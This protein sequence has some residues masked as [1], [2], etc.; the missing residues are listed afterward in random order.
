M[1]KGKIRSGKSATR[2]RSV[3]PARKAIF[4]ILQKIENE[5]AFSSELLPIYEEKLS[6][7]DRGLCHKIT[8]GV[9]RNKIYLDKSIEILTGKKSEKFDRAVLIA[10]RIGL[11]QL[12]FTD[13]IPI[14]SAVN[15]SVEMVNQ[16]KKRSAAGLV[17]AV[18]R[19]AAGEKVKFEFKDEIEKISIENS[20]PRWLLEKWISQFGL[21][22]TAKLVAA[23]NQTPNLS[24]RLTAKADEKTLEI[25]EKTGLQVRKSEIVPG[26]FKVSESSE[27]LRLYAEEGKIYFQDEGSQIV[28]H[29]VDLKAG[30]SFL[31][32]CAAPG[33]KT[34]QISSKFEVRS[35]KFEVQSSAVE[36]SQFA[37]GNPQF[38][39]A[40]DFYE[41]RVRFLRENC[42]R[43]GL[44]NV[45]IVRYD[46]ENTLPFANNS[47]DVAL[48]DAPC[49]GTGTIRRN[50]EIRYFLQKEDFAELSEKQLKILKNASK[51]IKSGGRLIY[52]TCS[53]EKEENETV[54]E[55]FLSANPDFI[56]I[57]PRVAEEFLTAEDFARTFPQRDE[58]D[59]FF[60]AVFEKKRIL[61]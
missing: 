38:I 52:S 5:K 44:K 3:S 54:C 4:E 18:L 40:G 1:S 27:I 53:L 22:E 2:N 6:I 14:Y 39:V 32:V 41:P 9:L 30:E 24:F 33:S 15:E 55:K 29:A 37:I 17:N 13:K 36:N 23:S 60:I 16:A 57:K 25:I 43:Q 28:A 19:R 12:L 58:T 42:A 35:S 8:L 59:G 21:E 49:T 7:I 26:A 51:L 10:L 56:K 20:F 45:S 11:F 47:F 31:D 48:V 34:T 50:P 46:A 61:K